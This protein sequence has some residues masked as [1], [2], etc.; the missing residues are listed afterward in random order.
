MLYLQVICRYVTPAPRGARVARRAVVGVLCAFI[1]LALSI[2]VYSPLHRDD[3]QQ[4][5]G[6]CPFCQF[7]HMVAKLGSAQVAFYVSMPVAR[8]SDVATPIIRSQFTH[9]THQGRAPPTSFPAI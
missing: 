9:R 8:C 5:N 6:V 2:I 1:L 3:P 7:Q 4:A